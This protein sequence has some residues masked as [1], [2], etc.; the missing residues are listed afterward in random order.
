MRSFL[1]NQVYDH[2]RRRTLSQ[3]LQNAD[4][5][6]IIVSD[7]KDVFD[8]VDD[9]KRRRTGVHEFFL[10]STSESEGEDADDEDAVIDS[11][12][13]DSGSIIGAP[14]EL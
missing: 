13:A 11:D 1:L 4:D 14:G 10:G 12:G 9:S 6:I 3:I 5:D 8:E 2:S 7:D